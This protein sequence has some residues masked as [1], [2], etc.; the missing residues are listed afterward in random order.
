[1]LRGHVHCASGRISA[2]SL[3]PSGR[4]WSALPQALVPPFPSVLYEPSCRDGRGSVLKGPL[5]PSGSY[6]AEKRSKTPI[7]LF[8]NP[9]ASPLQSGHLST[10]H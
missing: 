3:G 10:G 7:R 9:L 8:Q 2:P 1:M 5:R 4:R 6:S